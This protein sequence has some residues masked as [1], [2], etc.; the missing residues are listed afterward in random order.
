MQRT[1]YIVTDMQEQ[2]LAEI[3]ADQGYPAVL[4]W[5]RK[6]V[7]KGRRVLTWMDVTSPS[8]CVERRFLAQRVGLGD[9]RYRMEQRTFAFAGPAISDYLDG[10]GLSR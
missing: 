9:G 3:S 7:Q 5:V 1:A 6:H 8:G 4:E 2:V 10:V